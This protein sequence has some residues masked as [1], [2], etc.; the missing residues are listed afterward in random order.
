[1]RDFPCGEYPATYFPSGDTVTMV[2]AGPHRVLAR[3]LERGQAGLAEEGLDHP[4]V[5]GHHLRLRRAPDPG[6]SAGG[7]V[8]RRGRGGRVRV[9]AQVHRQL[10]RRALARCAAVGADG[11]GRRPRLAV[12]LHLD[13]LDVG[14]GPGPW[15]AGTVLSGQGPYQLGGHLLAGPG[16]GAPRGDA[17]VDGRGGPVDGHAEDLGVRGKC[18]ARGRSLTALRLQPLRLRVVQQRADQVFY[19]RC[20][21]GTRGHEYR[22]GHQYLVGRVEEVQVLGS[23]D[24]A[25]VVLVQHPE[26]EIRRVRDPPFA[27]HLGQREPLVR[28][29]PPGAARLRSGMPLLRPDVLA[30]TVERGPH[31]AGDAHR[32]CLAVLAVDGVVRDVDPV[33]HLDGPARVPGFLAWRADQV[34]PGDVLVARIADARVQEALHDLRR[35]PALLRSGRDGHDEVGVRR[36]IPRACAHRAG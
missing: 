24:L 9:L 32:G 10:L 6:L 25:E 8:E 7:V 27:V 36:G 12:D 31:L 16:H 3:G 19:Q 23:V 21:R 15:L 26:G 11:G 30:R 13:G 4:H 14:R 2:S 29:L 1:M 35:V 34:L 5:A 22:V 33:D 17:E 18:G 20:G 28:D